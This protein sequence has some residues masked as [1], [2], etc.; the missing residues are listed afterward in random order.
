MSI[1]LEKPVD[2]DERNNPRVSLVKET[3]TVEAAPATGRFAFLSKDAIAEH[4]GRSRT[5]TWS[6]LT[7]EHVTEAELT[8]EVITG[9]KNRH[10]TRE[11]E[12]RRGIKD[13]ARQVAERRT[14]EAR[15]GGKEDSAEVGALRAQRKAKKVELA[16]LTSEETVA[17]LD[18][19]PSKGELSRARWGRRAM[20]SATLGGA[21]LGGTVL[22]PMSDPTWLLASLPAAA[23]ALWR[24][25]LPVKD[26]DQ[27]EDAEPSV[28]AQGT[29]VAA[30]SAEL[31][32]EGP[33][34]AAAVTAARQAA[35]Y[36][37]TP[38]AVA[39]REVA[40][41]VE[42]AAQVQGSSDLITALL[43]AGII[44]RGEE[45]ETKVVG[46]IRPDGPG[47]TATV[48]LPGG[49]PAAYAIGRDTELASALKVKAP[50][51]QLAADT[52]EEGH[53]GRFVVW[54]ANSANP[55]AGPIVKSDLIGADSWDFWT[56]GVPLGSNARGVRKVLNMIWSS[57][58]IGGLMNYG[59][60]YLARLIAA[61]AVLDPYVK[62][63]LL[64]GKTGADWAAL[65]LVA[66][67]YVSGNSPA[68]IREM[69]QTMEETIAEM[70]AKGERLERLFEADP[71]A[72][73]EGKITPELAK[74]EGLELTLLVVE[75]LQEILDAAAGMKLH[76]S[77]DEADPD[78]ESGRKPAGRNGKEVMVSL[79]ARFIRVA[80]YVGGMEVIITQ[81]PDSTSVPTVLRE[82]APKRAC[83]RVKGRNSSKMV[84]G[85]D[86]VDGGAAPHLLMEHHKGVVVLDEGGEEGHDT[87]R[88]DVINL[89][90]FRL[91]CERGRDL[92]LQA[93]T[94]TGQAAKR[95]EAEREGVQRR[96]VVADAVAAMNA[97]GVD[98]ARLAVL[99]P[100]MAE[101][102]PE[103]WHDLT[104]VSLGTRLRD[105][106]AGNTVRIGAV[107][108]LTKASGYLRDD[109]VALLG[110]KAA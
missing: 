48:E 84:L 52:S 25:G 92:R 66:D 72:C 17:E 20:R 37:A 27:A 105:A 61:A 6:W 87:V 71:K 102:S 26:E 60:S 13:L 1:T 19:A 108:G 82:V 9:R 21:L 46:V 89:D 12:L 78:G 62:I 16:E 99:A 10:A 31:P 81:R 35:E 4:L 95:W 68:A 65:K 100:W 44:T 15:E 39:A 101:L 5:T 34:F 56:Q 79:F 107:D 75:E 74:T 88:A 91:I 109:L 53:E 47:W 23:V 50:Q 7:A 80:R 77:D 104:E 55:Y 93:G 96:Q 3:P 45:E 30:V 41:A 33:A 51:L 97:N 14:A 86:A 103:R 106:N 57:L 58:L 2:G 28:P 8:A 43:K 42:Q 63:V 54:C 22:L 18:D 36:S 40:K 73:P 59:K 32:L 29:P 90:D 64:T 11:R 83:Y 70:S 76:S 49:K 98:R 69:H 24:V 38:G 67:C 94:L 110:A 85:D